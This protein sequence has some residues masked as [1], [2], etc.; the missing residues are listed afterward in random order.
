M[1]TALHA[2]WTKLRTVAEVR[3]WLLAAAVLTAGLSAV[4][5]AATHAAPDGGDPDQSLDLTKLA[6]TGVHLGQLVVVLVA[7]TVM[8][9]EYGS[10]M[11]Q[12]TLAAVPRRWAVLA[13]KAAVVTAVV[14]VAGTV[15]VLGSLLAGRIVLERNGFTGADGLR[16]PAL[17]EGPTVRA[18]A[19]TVLYLVL[20]ALLSLGVATMVREAAVAAGSVLALLYVF[21]LMVTAVSD[22]DWQRHLRQIGPMT[23]GLSIQATVGVDSLPIGPWHGLGVLGLWAL[24]ALLAGAAL[25][26]L[27]DA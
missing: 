17:T 8:S 25:L 6:L 21:P 9:G 16:L 24:G 2:E 11:I 22:P 1:T 23:A 10:R 26:C 14:S 3:W 7:V 5:V 4:A 15:G 13:A 18:A 19:G 20:V 12:I 27:R